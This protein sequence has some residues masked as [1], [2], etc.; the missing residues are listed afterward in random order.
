MDENPDP[1]GPLIEQFDVKEF[2][3]EK[4][5]SYV[6]RCFLAAGFDTAEVI[7]SMDPSDDPGNSISSIE[8]FIDKYYHG[9][10]EFCCAPD[11]L[12]EQLPF[13]LPPGHRIRISNFI[14]DVKKACTKKK[15]LSLDS[16]CI[17]PKPKPRSKLQ[18]DSDAESETQ[19][20]SSVSCQIHC[21]ISKWVKHQPDVLLGACKRINS[22]CQGSQVRGYFCLY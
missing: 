15:P 1:K 4:L 14:S 5:P 3:K 7:A 8:Q 16:T 13:V 22:R 9:S 20:V 12:D 2:M 17:K 10:K 6:V 11:G 19:T 21:S 18:N